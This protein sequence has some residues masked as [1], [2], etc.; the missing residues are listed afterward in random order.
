[1]HYERANALF[2]YSVLLSQLGAMQNRNAAEGIFKV[3]EG[4][5]EDESRV[6]RRKE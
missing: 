1:M 6:R 5:W 3:N 4:G 2:N